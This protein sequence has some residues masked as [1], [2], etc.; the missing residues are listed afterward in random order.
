MVSRHRNVTVQ[1]P[2]G[3]FTQKWI[4]GV[5][6]TPIVSGATGTQQYADCVDVTG[7]PGADHPLSIEKRL[8]TYEPYNGYL[9]DAANANR[10]WMSNW[11]SIQQT[12][13]YGHASLP[14]PTT[15]NAASFLARVSPGAHQVETLENLVDIKDLPKLVKLAGDTILKR[16]AGAY[17][18]WQFGWKPLIS[19]VK[20]LLD[21]SARVDKKVRELHA[22]YDNGGVHRR[23]TIDK[24]TVSATSTALV[25]SSGSASITV[26]TNRFTQRTRWATTRF[27]PTT[28]PPKDET[29][30]RR[31]AIQIVYGL[32]LAPATIWEALPWSWMVDW[33]TNVGDYLVAYNN[34]CPVKA[35]PPCLMT[36]TRTDASVVRTDTYSNVTGGTA[37]AVTETKLRSVQTP[38]LTASIPFLT[39][40]QLSILG[41]LFIQRHRAF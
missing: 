16:G 36:Y 23:R 14:T 37:T 22:L 34:V 11:I 8:I 29:E 5:P 4:A 10:L 33:F 15:F 1:F 21:F 17:L 7:S 13:S 12:S 9:P 2:A 3:G 32:D 28:L 26:K 35:T 38:T 6:Q 41:A 18:T 24:D 39:G 25:Q 27:V 19:D 30:Y 20:K 40:R 31:R